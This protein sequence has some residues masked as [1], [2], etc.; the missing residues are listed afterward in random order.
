VA[1]YQVDS[2][3]ANFLFLESTESPTHISLLYLYDQSAMGAR[4]VRF[5]EIRQHLGQRINSAPVFRQKV[6]F[7]PG[8]IDFPYWE[9]DVRFDLD[10]H[11]RHI[12]LPKPGDWRQFCI[13]ISRLHS[14]PLDLSRPLWELYVIEG[15]D[16][17]E[18]CPPGSFALY[19]KVHHGAMDE[20]TALE[21]MQSLHVHTPDAQDHDRARQHVTHLPSAAPGA[22]E[23]VVR[24]LINNTLR[25]GRLALQ[26]AARYRTLG[27]IA[28]GLG[29][30]LMRRAVDGEP[31]SGSATTRFA[32]PLGRAR[33]FEGGFYARSLIERFA[34]E[35]PGATP[36]HVVLAICGEAMRAY[37]EQHGELGDESLQALLTVNVRNA[38]AHA[39]IGN[40]IAVNQIALHTATAYPIDRLQAIYSSHNHLHSIEGGE[41]TSIRLRSIYENLPAP[42][43]AWLGRNAQRKNSVGQRLLSTGNC[44]V[45]E[46]T[47]ST[48]PLYLLGARLF[49]FTGIPPVYN[50]C[51]LMFTASTYGDKLSLT[52]TSDRDMLPDPHRMRQCLDD[53]VLGIERY[54][55]NGPHPSRKSRPEPAKKPRAGSRQSGSPV[56]AT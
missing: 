10:F 4:K 44:G 12:A 25:S 42:V 29:F 43:M 52:F 35:V 13:Q 32:K 36:S 49:G 26:M 28:A 17:V 53:A 46:M 41:L 9:D 14:R 40:R 18:G 20:F 31:V 11:V 45:T 5:T 39:L 38:G 34:A 56:G 15:L 2:E 23:M 37:L 50:G 7:V 16:Q 51:G 8:N 22:V 30:R 24:G 48:R 33:I 21:L 55:A 54:L 3:D 19:F 47:G 1:I 27:K 6:R